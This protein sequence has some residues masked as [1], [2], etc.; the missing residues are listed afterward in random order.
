MLNITGTTLNH[1]PTFRYKMPALVAKIE[2]RGNGI[3]TIVVN[4]RTIAD[5]I[6]RPPDLLMRFM[7]IEL[8]AQSKGDIDADRAHRVTRRRNT[9][10]TC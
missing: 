7:A 8:G 6:C 3:K 2:G 10:R 4:L 1:D 5:A 9:S